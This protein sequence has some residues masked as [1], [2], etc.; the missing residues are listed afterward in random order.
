MNLFTCGLYSEQFKMRFIVPRNSP[1]Y[2]RTVNNT[3]IPYLILEQSL[4]RMASAIPRRGRRGR[5][6]RGWTI[7][8]GEKRGPFSRSDVATGEGWDGWSGM[9]EGGKWRNRKRRRRWRQRWK[10]RREREREGGHLAIKNTY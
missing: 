2:D 1:V 7:L 10:R 3:A 9:R 6:M 8:E 5:R 4:D